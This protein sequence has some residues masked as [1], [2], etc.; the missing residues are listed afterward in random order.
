MASS[1]SVGK[2]CM[3]REIHFPFS[4]FLKLPSLST[5]LTICITRTANHK[6]WVH[7]V[8]LALVSRTKRLFRSLVRSCNSRRNL[9]FF[10]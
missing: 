5:E 3:S 8:K 10:A 4:F 7:A 1:G 2:K 6:K 9:P